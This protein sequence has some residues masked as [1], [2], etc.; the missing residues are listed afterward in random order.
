VALFNIQRPGYIRQEIPG[1]KGRKPLRRE[2]RA[3]WGNYSS[4]LRD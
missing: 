4:T 3:K 1:K 2:K